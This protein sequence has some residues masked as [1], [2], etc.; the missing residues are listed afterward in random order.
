[1]CQTLCLFLLVLKIKIKETIKG[2]TFALIEILRALQSIATTR[3]SVCLLQIILSCS[4]RYSTMK[5]CFQGYH[6]ILCGACSST[7]G[8]LASGECSACGKTAKNIIFACFLAIWMTLIG[9]VMMKSALAAR[10][11]EDT[12]ENLALE[13]SDQ[14]HYHSEVLKVSTYLIRAFNKLQNEELTLLMTFWL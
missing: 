10:N 4:L 5:L 9:F 7:H 13:G 14:N 11:A 12:C 1:M 6:G 3:P 2:T 8:K